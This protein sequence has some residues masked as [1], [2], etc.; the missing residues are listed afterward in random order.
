MRPYKATAAPPFE[1]KPSW[2]G[3]YYAD[4]HWRTVRNQAG[5]AIIYATSAA[6]IMQAKRLAEEAKAT[7]EADATK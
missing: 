2:H 7:I 4:G 3:L 6:A 1:G 5:N